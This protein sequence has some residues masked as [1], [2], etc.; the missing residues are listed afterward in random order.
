MSLEGEKEEENASKITEQRQLNKIHW[1]LYLA[2]EY[3]Y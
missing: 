2:N 3:H 1:S